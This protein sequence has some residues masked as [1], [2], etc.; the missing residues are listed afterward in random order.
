MY[1]KSNVNDD[2][3]EKFRKLLE[4]SCEIKTLVDLSE[5][6]QKALDLFVEGRNLLIIGSAGVGKSFLIKEMKYQAHKINPAKKMVV[7]AT[8]GIAAYN[9]NGITINSF[10]GIGTGEYDVDVLIKRVRRKIG[11]RERLRNTDILVIDEI[12]MASAE[13]FEKID[14]VCKTIRKSSAPFGG[15]QVVLTGDFLQL[16]PVFNKNSKLYPNQDK[17]LIFE[18]PVFKSIFKS[19]NTITL[20]S[21][22]RQNDS[23][24]ID[25]LMRIRRGEYT[26]EDMCVISSRFVNVLNPSSSDLDSA[27]HI[28]T[29]NKQAQLINSSNLQS[30]NK[31]PIITYKAVFTEEGNS[32]ACSDLTKELKAQFTQKGILEVSLKLGARVML[33]KNMSVEEGLVNGSV[34][35]VTSF[36][37]NS[38]DDDN[39]HYPV[40]NFDNGVKRMIVMA[41]WNIELETNVAR[42]TQLPL[43][44]CWAITVHRCQSL[45]LEKAVLSLEDAFCD[46]M[47]Y[48]ALSRVRTLNGIYLHSFDK[49]K[50]TVN[51]KVKKYIGWP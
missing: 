22:F 6:Q 19:Q 25:M 35:T 7:T 50:L 21:N 46:H 26:H 34:G 24:F 37:K 32:D 33:I 28:V 20:T 36:N 1:N 30:I 14:A 8:T 15:I 27:V 5:S 45:T 9:I 48:V 38:Y 17:R 49:K 44:L 23:S 4:E 10:M 40:V 51:E 42:A 43:M 31:E 13:L 11:V 16:L 47:V 18:S 3:M 2:M 39:T 29:S 12:S 41:D